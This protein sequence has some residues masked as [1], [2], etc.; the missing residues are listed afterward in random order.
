MTLSSGLAV[1]AIVLAAVS[2]FAFPFAL[3]AAVLLLG[4]AVLIQQGPR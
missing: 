2:T 4:V 3:H 1:G